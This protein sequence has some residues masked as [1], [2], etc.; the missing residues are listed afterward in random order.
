MSLVERGGLSSRRVDL[1]RW[2]VPNTVRRRLLLQ[3]ILNLLTHSLSNILRT[4]APTEILSLDT[5][6]GH[7]LDRLHQAIGNLV[8]LAIADPPHHLRR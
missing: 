8:Q 6:H 2:N 3:H 5:S 7:V 1:R 4:L